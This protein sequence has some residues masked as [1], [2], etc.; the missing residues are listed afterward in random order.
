MSIRSWVRDKIEDFGSWLIDKIIEPALDFIRRAIQN[1]VV[2]LRIFRHNLKAKLAKWME[3]DLFFIIFLQTIVAAFFYVPQLAAQAATWVAT[4]WVKNMAK[5]IGDAI[6][7][8]IDVNKYIDFV[9]LH[10]ILL[11]IWEDYKK[12]AY[13]FADAVSQLSSELGEGSAYLHAYFAS[14]RGIMHGSNAILGG[15]PLQVEIEW[16]GRTADFFEKANDRFARYA[17]DPGRLL[18]DFLNEV[19]IPAAEEQRDV[20]QAEMDE[21]RNNRDR[22]VEIDEG[23]KLLQDSINDF[24]DL[25]P[26]AIAEQINRVWEPINEK[27]T[28]INEVVF[29][30]MMNLINGVVDA[31]E[32][33]YQAQLA[34]NDAAEKNAAS[35]KHLADMMM[36][37]EDDERNILSGAYDDLITQG[38]I[39]ETG[40]FGDLASQYRRDY[41]SITRA[42]ILGLD[43]S[44]ALLL[45]YS[46]SANKPDRVVNVPSPFIGDF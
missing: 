44:P 31:V 20:S 21:I 11:L 41:D 33:H 32:W 24:M 34:I 22:L 16:Y 27:W 19:L 1:I 10:K 42:Y 38:L 30:E 14:L 15:D 29:G 37:M 46:G 23:Q 35:G 26:N 45:E 40:E 13:A 28:E 9:L 25:Q 18:Y 36:T 12:T 6:V 4:L 17:R 8:V 5:Q 7:D 3:N 39:D 2:A 43:I